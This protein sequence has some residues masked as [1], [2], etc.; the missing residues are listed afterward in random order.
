[1]PLKPLKSIRATLHLH[2]VH[3]M[4]TSVTVVHFLLCCHCSF[5]LLIVLAGFLF[6]ISCVFAAWPTI[7]FTMLFLR[8]K[9]PVARKP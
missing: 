1:M 7:S 4:H 9:C 2:T 3:T 8:L 6:D 5:L